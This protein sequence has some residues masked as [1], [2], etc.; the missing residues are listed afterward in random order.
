MG[1]LTLLD[2]KT[3][4]KA[5]E[6]KRGEK[7]IKFNNDSIFN[8][9]CWNTSKKKKKKKLDTDITPFTKISSKW[10]T[11]VNVSHNDKTLRKK[12]R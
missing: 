8:K 1:R 11:D 2:F 6:F 9:W 10:I 5:I 12:S 4:N 7:V 3:Y